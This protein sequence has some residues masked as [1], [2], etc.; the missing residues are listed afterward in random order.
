MR[1]SWLLLT[2]LFALICA[3]RSA[4]AGKLHVRTVQQ[5]TTFAEWSLTNP[6]WEGNPFDVIGTVTFEHIDS[7]RKRVTEMFY[8]GGERWKFRFTGTRPGQWRFETASPDPDL[9]GHT[10]T[11]RVRASEPG[12]HG[13]V[14]AA[15]NRWAWQTGRDGELRAFVPQLVMYSGDLSEIARNP[16]RLRRDVRVFLDGHGFTGFH[17]P[18]IGGRWFDIEASARVE[19][20][21]RN[22]DPRSFAALERAI[23]EVHAAGGMVHIWAWGDQQRKQTPIELPGGK[24]GTADRR[25]QRYV[26]ARLGPVPGWSMGYGFDLDEWAEQPEVKAWHDYL[27]DHMGWLHFL[28]GRPEGPNRGTDHSAYRRWNAPLDYAGYEHHRPAY[29]VYA[30]ALRA[31]PGKP[32]MSED[33]FRIR[34]KY[35]DKDYTEQLTRRGLYHSTMAGGVANIWGYLKEPEGGYRSGGR[36]GPYPHEEWIKTYSVFFFDRARF[37]TDLRV[38][39]ELTDGYA[40]AAPE[41]SG[42]LFYVEDAD[43]VRVDLSGAS[44]PPGAVAVDT[45]REYE[46]LE[47]GE[48]EPREQRLRLPHASDWTVAVGSLR[49][50]GD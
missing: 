45:R 42:Y 3:V 11:V 21:M 39:N 15:G 6:D 23:A 28:G 17:V 33:R 2:A 10:G 35:P 5:W 27:H 26:A 43:S 22:P 7:A 4:H 31:N 1:T 18:S 41:G 30:A 12:V 9:D 24:N 38:A 32:V 19:P 40:L 37:R 8:D 20:G 48:L 36:S 49:A 47:L 14:T 16:A 46:E 44:G 29:E 13:F 50:P 34:G 25:L